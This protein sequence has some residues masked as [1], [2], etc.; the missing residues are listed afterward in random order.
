LKSLITDYNATKYE[1]LDNYRSRKNIVAFANAF[2][3]KLA[4]RLKTTPIKATQNIDGEVCITKYKSPNLS[5]P[6][7]Q[8]ILEKSLTGSVCV[9]TETNDEA[10]TIAG[11]L[12]KD[13]RSVR[14]IQDNKGFNIYN[15]IEIRYF[16]DALNLR[17]DVYTIDD[18]AWKAAKAKTEREY[19]ESIAYEYIKNLIK[20]FEETN[21]KT[22]YKTDFLQFIKESKL[23]DFCTTQNSQILVSTI[24]KAKGREFDNVFLVLKQN[25]T[26]DD[27]KRT[28]YVAMTRAKNNLYIHCNVD[29]FGGMRVENVTEKLD[30]AVYQE[31]NEI[32]V[33]I[34]YKGVH[35]SS[36]YYFKNDLANLKSGE[37][38]SVKREPVRYSDGREVDKYFCFSTVGKKV[39]QFSN[40]M[41][42]KIDEMTAKGYIPQSATVRLIVW[43]KK[44]DEDGKEYPET[45][46]ILPDIHFVRKGGH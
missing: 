17:D 37:A 31:P 32:V 34:S 41:N 22:K 44:T 35:L 24:H 30:E 36:F 19:L 16:V 40:A 25:P 28:V 11:L 43:W 42:A 45:K 21:P 29:C 46:I 12:T 23:E 15:L 14:L 20:D 4:S 26:T 10:A 8:D 39:I 2:A 18:E 38:L 33:P 1:L 13:D 9:L 6:V 3:Q 7:V 27:K 5:V